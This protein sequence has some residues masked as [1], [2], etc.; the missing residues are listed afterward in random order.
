ML[1][2]ND[3]LFSSERDV[4]KFLFAMIGL[5]GGRGST[6]YVCITFEALE[7][8]PPY[9]CTHYVNKFDIKSMQYFVLSTDFGSP[10]CVHAQ[11]KPHIQ[12]F[13]G[14]VNFVPAVAVT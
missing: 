12:Y 13:P 7:P 8:L 4:Q 3:I 9:P 1:V 2:Q 6:K 11:W 10:L 14:F 5:G